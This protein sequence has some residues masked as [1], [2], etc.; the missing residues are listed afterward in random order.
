MKHKYLMLI[1]SW[2][3]SLA[4]YSSK[5]GN[6]SLILIQQL[7]S[8]FSVQVYRKNRFSF[9]SCNRVDILSKSSENKRAQHAMHQKN[10]A[11]KNTCK[12]Y[13]Y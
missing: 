5:Y 13:H 3:N 4:G 10:V 2:W 9:V 6:E 8:F 7:Q 1:I 12:V 11:N